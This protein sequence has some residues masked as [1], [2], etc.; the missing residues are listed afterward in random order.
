MAKATPPDELDREAWLRN[1]LREVDRDLK[2]SRKANARTA[3]T[4]LHREARTIRAELDEVLEA[5]R[6]TQR[7]P[8]ADLTEEELLEEQLEVLRELPEH[9]LEPLAEVVVERLGRAAVERIMREVLPELRVLVGGG[10]E[11]A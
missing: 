11:D 10:D 4:H 1:Q 3:I 6:E 9:T 2:A 8:Y 7:D 5:K